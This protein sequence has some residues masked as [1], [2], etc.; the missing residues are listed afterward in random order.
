MQFV[1]GNF[2]NCRGPDDTPCAPYAEEATAMT[3]IA[4]ARP[5]DI[6]TGFF[7]RSWSDHEVN[8]CRSACP[9]SECIGSL[10]LPR[11]PPPQYQFALLK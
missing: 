6:A 9:H 11:Y 1:E 5:A 7:W 4:E 2:A 10:K 8:P 3:K